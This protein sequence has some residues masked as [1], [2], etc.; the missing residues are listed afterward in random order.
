MVC[1][2]TLWKL[3]LCWSCNLVSIECYI[4]QGKYPLP[5]QV[6]QRFSETGGELCK[7]V[8]LLGKLQCERLTSNLFIWFRSAVGKSGLMTT[9]SGLRIACLGGIYDAE[10]YTST[11]T[12]PVCRTTIAHF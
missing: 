2:I 12:P 10:I 4:M 1:L 3:L 5:R 11:D 8:F 7:N 9:A 6:I